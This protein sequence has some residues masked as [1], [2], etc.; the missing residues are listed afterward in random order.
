M[1]FEFGA[2]GGTGFSLMKCLGKCMGGDVSALALSLLMACPFE[3]QTGIIQQSGSSTV[4]LRERPGLDP[5]PPRILHRQ[6]P[7]QLELGRQRPVRRRVRSGV[8]AVQP[9]HDKYTLLLAEVRVHARLQ[10][11]EDT[12]GLERWVGAG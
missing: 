5:N 9:G 11:L 8:P 10:V 2:V 1:N 6:L 4:R 7:I 3:K 12:P